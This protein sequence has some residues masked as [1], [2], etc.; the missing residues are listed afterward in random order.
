MLSILRQQTRLQNARRVLKT[1]WC[2]FRVFQFQPLVKSVHLLH[3]TATPYNNALLIASFACSN[4]QNPR[5]TISSRPQWRFSTSARQSTTLS[6]KV[7]TPRAH[8]TQI[9]TPPPGAFEDF[10]K[11]FKSS[12][13]EASDALEGLNIDDEGEDYDFMDDADAP[14][15]R[16]GGNQ[17]AP[18]VK[19]MK[20][21]QDVADRKVSDIVIELDDLEQVG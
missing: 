2:G 9:L 19:Y 11:S 17:Q 12:T 13:V 6:N 7:W 18:K 10:L 1:V 8:A 21:L 15:N 14:N 5:T 16:T 20:L 3:S 4:S